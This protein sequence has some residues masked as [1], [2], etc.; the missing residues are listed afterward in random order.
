MA[1]TAMTVLGEAAMTVVGEGFQEGD[2]CTTPSSSSHMFDG[3][4]VSVYGLAG[5][6]LFKAEEVCKCLGIKEHRVATRG[7]EDYEKTSMMFC[8][9]N[10]HS[11]THTMVT[12]AGVYLIGKSRKTAA[13]KFR[14][15]V[16]TEVLPTIRRTGSYSMDLKRKREDEEDRERSLR[17]RQMEVD[18]Q[19]RSIKCVSTTMALMKSL[20]PLDDRDVL[21]FKSQVAQLAPVME[22]P[23]IAAGS[24]VSTSDG[25]ARD[26]SLS[27]WMGLNGLSQYASN[28]KL[29]R[30]I[31]KKVSA[32]YQ[33][34]H[35]R[36][37]TQHKQYVDGATRYVNTYYD[38]DYDEFAPI[39]RAMCV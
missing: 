39:I 37:P 5:T 35:K 25:T 21:F 29:L 11:Q 38:Q 31:G 15:W 12:E 19:E 6:P 2:G 7:M 14:K 18:I 26:L 8:D 32:A 23:A 16:H 33:A 27:A 28:N 24:A 22:V 10:G 3:Q 36:K 30:A 9:A 1:D 4:M 34:K 17:C 20:G 13:K